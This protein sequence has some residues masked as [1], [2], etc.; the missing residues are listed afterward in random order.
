MPLDVLGGTSA[1]LVCS[2]SVRPHLVGLGNLCTRHRDGDRLL[3]LL[4]FNAEFLVSASHQLVLTTP[5][6]FVHAAR[7]SY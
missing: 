4:I 6:P 7:R 2:A 1:A 3:P 5:L